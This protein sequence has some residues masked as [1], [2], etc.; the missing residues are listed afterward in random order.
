[1]QLDIDDM[2]CAGCGAPVARAPQAQPTQGNHC[3]KCGMI[4]DTQK[5]F[6]TKCGV[7]LKNASV[8]VEHTT[9]PAPQYRESERVVQA[10]PTSG[11]WH[12]YAVKQEENRRVARK[13]ITLFIV[14]ISLIALIFIIAF[15]FGNL[16]IMAVAVFPTMIICPILGARRIK[17]KRY[18]GG[19]VRGWRKI[20][21]GCFATILAWIVLAWAYW[22]MTAVAYYDACLIVGI[23]T[24]GYDFFRDVATIREPVAS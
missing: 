12:D 6:C 20:T 22:V 1:M 16:S 17:A 21:S 7:Q 10:A 14:W 15:L 13:Y 9:P 11:V 23:F 3:P 8:I 18:W 2:F 4:N 19:V 24:S 5:K